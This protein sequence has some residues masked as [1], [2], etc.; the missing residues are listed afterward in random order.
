MSIADILRKT[1]SWLESHR[2]INIL[3][4]GGYFLFIY[5]MH[6]PVV[7]LSVW[8]MNFFT[9]PVY[10]KVV[11]G[12]FALFLILFTVFLIGQ[13]KEHK[14][15]RKLKSIYLFVTLALI[16]IHFRIMFE[17]N[18]EIIHIFE[19]SILAV[20]LFPLTRRFGATLLFTIPF[21]LLDEWHQ[22]IVL[23]PGYVEYFEF[24]DV[25]MDMYGCG[26]AMT[27]LLICNLNG[28]EVKVLWKRPEF[29]SLCLFVLFVVIALKTCFICSYPHEKCSNTFLVLNGI[30]GVQTFWHQYPG[31]DVVYH[32]MQPIEALIYIP[33]LAFF[34]FGLDSF[35]KQV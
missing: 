25:V 21:M 18:I 4:A 20:L 6:D 1:I 27:A 32:V 12:I 29:I 7:H 17:M 15:N 35:R 3:L 26:L 8:V 31:R 2:F 24:N 23:Y 14:D 28:P 16:V 34:Y 19:F 33:L 5:F 13:L 11:L 10:N 22:Y 30:Q 9:L